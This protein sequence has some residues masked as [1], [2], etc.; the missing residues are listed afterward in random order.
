[1]RE[2]QQLLQM[3]PTQQAAQV[4]AHVQAQRSQHGPAAP[5]GIPQLQVRRRSIRSR[6][7]VFCSAGGATGAGA[8]PGAALTADASCIRGDTAA[9]GM[10]ER[11]KKE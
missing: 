2:L 7:S 6:R 8:C 10:Q 3:A 4:Q 5:V 9:A 11:E 1:M